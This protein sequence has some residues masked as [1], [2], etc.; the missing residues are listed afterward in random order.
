MPSNPWH[1]IDD[2]GSAPWKRGR[3]EPP[4]QGGTEGVAES[5]GED[6]PSPSEPRIQ[7]LSAAFEPHPVHGYGINKYCRIRGQAEFLEPSS[8]TRCC[9]TLYS[10]F[11]GREEDL[12]IKPDKY[13]TTHIAAGSGDFCF[14]DVPLY[15]PGGYPDREVFATPLRYKGVIEAAQARKPIE[16]IL[17]LP[18]PLPAL[19]VLKQGMFD[20]H[21][22]SKYRHEY[23]GKYA[24]GA[25]GYVAGEPVY[26]FQKEMELL[27]YL[28]AGTANGVF[29]SRTDEVCRQF[30]QDAG[31]L[32]RVDR[33]G[34]KLLEAGSVTYNDVVDGEVGAAV[35][36]ELA[37]WKREEYLRPLPCLYY[38]DYDREAV[39]KGIKSSGRGH[40]DDA[41]SRRDAKQ[42]DYHA[43]G[44]PV[45]AAQK[46][47]ATI[48]A[49]RG[50]LDGWYSDLMRDAVRL[51][52]QYAQKGEFL[53]NGEKSEIEEKL[54]GHH[55]GSCDIPTQELAAKVAQMGGEVPQSETSGYCFPLDKQY[56]DKG[57]HS[58]MRSFG[59]PRSNGA[60]YHAG[61]DLY[62]PLGEKV[63]AV[64]DGTITAYHNYYWKTFALVVDHGD[65]I[66][67]YGEVQPPADPEKHG[68]TDKDVK[69]YIEKLE[70][71]EKQG[72]SG[73]LQ[74][75]SSVKKGEH[76]A[77]VGQL[78]ENNGTV[79]FKN[80]MVHFEKY[81][82]TATGPL[83]QR[84]YTGTY[85]HL[86]ADKKHLT[87]LRR[88]DLENPT[89]F[90]DECTFE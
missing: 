43:T 37:V 1:D 13:G 42:D 14:S 79:P 24:S 76:I 71:E 81:K 54:S 50:A 40:R 82:K 25:E 59:S 70:V 90:L 64:A 68:I 56:Q 6:A 17:D 85:E 18:A 5:G 45:L 12:H 47:L 44:T 28:P 32:L 89:L 11:E 69:D 35:R 58:G 34:G 83:T 21:A 30:Q 10:V 63:F 66:A 29:G 9:L 4:R 77:Y 53:I 78:Y 41:Q 16:C 75:G 61:C 38:G 26:E 23:P 57:Y 84:E 62:A 51:F 39:D 7:F 46:I 52:Q 65:F 49:Y 8:C 87:F 2:L 67:L 74:K 60:R 22:V 80:T 73:T 19:P 33:S 88:K 55:Q 72:L 86:E 36:D 3:E 48:G 31:A 20:D 15:V 27:R